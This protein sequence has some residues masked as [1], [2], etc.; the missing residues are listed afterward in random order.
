MNEASVKIKAQ[1]GVI[2]TYQGIIE[3]QREMEVLEHNA[4]IEL[5]GI[6]ERVM[7]LCQGGKAKEIIEKL[8]SIK[9]E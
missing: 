5:L 9:P 8:N 2:A 7:R 1:E 4:K 3:V 6:L